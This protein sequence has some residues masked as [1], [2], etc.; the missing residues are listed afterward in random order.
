[1]ELLYKKETREPIS[2]LYVKQVREP[3]LDINYLAQIS[4]HTGESWQNVILT[5]ST[6]RPALTNKIPELE[7]WFI[8][9]MPTRKLSVRSIEAPTAVREDTKP[10]ARLTGTEAEEE[11]GE[12]EE[13][14]EGEPH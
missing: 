1:M 10:V 7:P 14:E 11:D 13:E 2:S 6:A 8:S 9:P 12:E 4:Q 5:L 3:V